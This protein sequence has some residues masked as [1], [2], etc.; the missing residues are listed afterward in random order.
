MGSNQNS[1]VPT[2]AMLAV[3]FAMLYFLMIRPQKKREKA[4][5]EMRSALKVGDEIVTIGGVIGKVEKITDRT[6]V[7]STTAAKSKIEF[8][9][10]SVASVNKA[11]HTGDTPSKES[12]KI[13]EGEKT[14]NRD[15]KVTP[16]K[17]GKKS[18]E[19]K[20]E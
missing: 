8:L 5:Q 4:D 6:I 10:T 7:I 20:T 9:K 18:E 15:K 19:E 2:I 17:L 1:M 14:P 11:V 12:A 13:D 3:M 16:K